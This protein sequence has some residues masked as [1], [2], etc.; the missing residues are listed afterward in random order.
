MAQEKLVQKRRVKVA[1]LFLQLYALTHIA[2]GLLL[3]WLMHTSLFTSYLD[4]LALAF[5]S[6]SSTAREQAVFLTGLMGPTIASWGLLFFLVV[7]QA[8][9]APSPRWWWGMVLAALLWA[10][11]DSA[12]SWQEGMPLNAHIN[13]LSLLALLAPLW[14][15]RHN[16]LHAHSYSQQD[17]AS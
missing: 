11:Y 12:L 10:P 16:F 14:L 13:A 3:P 17:P 1:K 9:S 5:N 8:F 7:T 6:N 2:G 15:V 4:Q